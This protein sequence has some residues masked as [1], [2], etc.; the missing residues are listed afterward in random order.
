MASSIAYF[1]DS[2][3]AAVPSLIVFASRLVVAFVD[4]CC[5]FT[6][7]V[8]HFLSALSLFTLRHLLSSF[9]ENLNAPLLSRLE[10]LG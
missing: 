4:F 2:Q 1:Y 6:L 10:L 9:S 5:T 8:F 3:S 7:S